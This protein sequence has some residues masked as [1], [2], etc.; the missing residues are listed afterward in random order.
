M[1][2]FMGVLL[3]IGMA[4]PSVYAAAG[5]VAGEFMRIG[6]GARAVAMGE[7]FTAVADGP[8]AAYWNPAG[9]MQVKKNEVDFSYTDYVGNI[10]FADL[11]YA[12]PYNN[13]TIGLEY[14]TLYVQDDQ[15]DNN[16]NV[17]GHFNDINNSVS[18]LYST[19]LKKGLYIGLGLKGIF[20]QLNTEQANGASLDAGLLYKYDERIKFGFMYQNLLGTDIQYPGDQGYP[21]ARYIKLGISY[22]VIDRFLVSSDINLPVDAKKSV[23]LGC[24]YVFGR[25][26]AVRAGYKVKEGG[27]EMGGL[28]G[29]SA[30]FG[31]NLSKYRVDYALAPYGSFGYNHR[32]SLGVS[33]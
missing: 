1:K 4:A 32:I 30:G 2:Y 16:G 18:F 33:F 20:F 27:S 25:L 26:F 29:F 21:L 13:C 23:N 10:K 9:L 17:T 5:R 6:V 22:Q 14:N 7:A 8:A 19:E 31:F 3:M 11:S 12:Y 24:E 15:R 28:D